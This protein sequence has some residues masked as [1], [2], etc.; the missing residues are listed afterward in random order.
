MVREYKKAIRDKIPDVIKA[1][2]KTCEFIVLDDTKFL[3][4]MNKKLYE[5]MEEYRNSESIEEIVDILEVA[6]RI[7]ELKGFN[8]KEIEKIRE[9]K[10]LKNGNFSKNI[11]L[12]S[13]SS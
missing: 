4:E 2:G 10:N 12:V 9:E 3:H 1:D 7:A 8:K 6:Y 13:S 11:F 5:E